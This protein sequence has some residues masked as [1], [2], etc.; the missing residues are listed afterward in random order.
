MNE[1]RFQEA[2]DEMQYDEVPAGATDVRPDSI[3][4]TH[5]PGGEC[6]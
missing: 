4:N 3:D 6:A 5:P 2:L 1:Y